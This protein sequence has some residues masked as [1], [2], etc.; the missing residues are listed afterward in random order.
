M[1][2][3]PSFAP[4]IEVART[5]GNTGTGQ[6]DGPEGAA[7]A[8]EADPEEPAGRQASLPQASQAP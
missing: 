5:E 3:A 7:S 1:G 2:I 4:R 8:V 6:E